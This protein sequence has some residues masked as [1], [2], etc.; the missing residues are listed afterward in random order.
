MKAKVWLETIESLIISKRRSKD[1]ALH[2]RELASAVK[3]SEHFANKILTFY[4]VIMNKH[5]SEG[6]ML[7]VDELKECAD[8]LGMRKLRVLAEVVKTGLEEFTVSEMYAKIY[9]SVK[10]SLPKF[11]EY[12]KTYVEKGYLE[13]V[14][15]GTYRLTEKS[16][17]VLEV[18][19]RL[20]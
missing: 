14:D 3:E 4:A 13:K 10:V 15:R 7:T 6:M 20:E 9:G 18:L 17:K 16:K 11:S 1:V 12:L 2:H 19:S 8:E 5:Y